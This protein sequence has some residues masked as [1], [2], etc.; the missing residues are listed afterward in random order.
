MVLAPAGARE[1]DMEVELLS[2]GGSNTYRLPD[3]VTQVDLAR[4]ICI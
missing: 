4:G 2:D 1:Q 3:N